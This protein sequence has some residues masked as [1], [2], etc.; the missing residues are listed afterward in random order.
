MF[1]QVML[2]ILC[3]CVCR[4]GESVGEEGKLSNNMQQNKKLE[5]WE[6]NFLNQSSISSCGIEDEEDHVKQQE[7]SH[8]QNNN[9][10]Q[11]LQPIISS[12]WPYNINHHQ[13]VSNDHTTSPKSSCVSNT[14]STNNMLDFAHKFP[15]PNSSH[16]VCTYIFCF[17]L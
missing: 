7:N 11:A 2:M 4:G 6:H 17:W 3:F 16:E 1:K 12:S 9:F 8:Q 10:L 14:L 5:N 15:D 13:I